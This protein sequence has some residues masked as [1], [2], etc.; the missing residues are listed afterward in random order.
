[1]D[2]KFLR[3]IG[4]I[5]GISTFITCLYILFDV[6]S[7]FGLSFPMGV[8]II[9]EPYRSIVSLYATLIAFIVAFII[10]SFKIHIWFSALCIF[11]LSIISLI[12][13][14]SQSIYGLNFPYTL[15]PFIIGFI[16]SLSSSIIMLFK[17]EKPI[18]IFSLTPMEISITA[19]L[20]ALQA[21]LTASVGA[22]F[23][24]PTGGYTH[25]GDTITFLAA[26][27]FGVKISTLTGVIGSL[28]ADFYLA[29]PRWYVTIL[30]HG[31]EGLIAGL[32]YRKSFP[33]KIFLS[34]IAGFSMAFTYFYINIFIKGYAPAIISFMRDFFGQA[35]ISI[36]L[37]LILYKPLERILKQS[38]IFK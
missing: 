28:I 24:S 18:G 19:I 22:I 20:S 26:Y 29:Y 30:A 32:S 13:L 4:I 37:A 1:M 6:F 8:V 14:F 38:Y 23:P 16:L 7:M 34:I 12:A 15:I 31:V 27:L 21:F 35:L 17:I 5:G 9:P 3:V 10:S 33:I 2:I 36:I 25:I 11:S